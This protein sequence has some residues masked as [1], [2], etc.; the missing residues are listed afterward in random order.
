[1]STVM[2][3]I[4]MTKSESW[5]CRH[6]V[7]PRPHGRPACSAAAEADRGA[8]VA[9]RHSLPRAS[10]RDHVPPHALHGRQRNRVEKGGALQPQVPPPAAAAAAT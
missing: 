6:D 9:T 4:D 2:A 5:A 10:E 1:M 3:A 7:A 8:K